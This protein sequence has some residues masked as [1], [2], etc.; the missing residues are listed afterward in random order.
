MRDRNHL[1]L[2]E[3]GHH[4]YVIPQV[5]LAAGYDH[6]AA[7]TVLADFRKPLIRR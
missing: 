7:R 5:R 2:G 1:E 6:R 4:V 3:S